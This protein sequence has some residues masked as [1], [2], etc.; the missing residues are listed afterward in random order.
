MKCS[1]PKCDREIEKYVSENEDA[2]GNKYCAD[3]VAKFQL[4]AEQE[5]EYY[6]GDE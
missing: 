5:G 1:N 4:F 3:C 6:D 2:N